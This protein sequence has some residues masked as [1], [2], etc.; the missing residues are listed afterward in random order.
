MLDDK[1]KI[2]KAPQILKLDDERLLYTQY[3]YMTSE[4]RVMD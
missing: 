3:L 4:A 1:C 2:L